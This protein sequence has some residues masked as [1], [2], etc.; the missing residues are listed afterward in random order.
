MQDY[1]DI[2]YEL[3]VSLFKSDRK[4]KE[5]IMSDSE[6]EVIKTL[7][8]EVTIYRGMSKDEYQSKKYRFSWTLDKS[9]AEMFVNR[10]NLLYK[11]E[12]VVCELIIPKDKIVAYFEERE[13]KEVI[14]LG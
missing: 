13:E 9:I 3:T 10:N 12:F 8:N 4:E 7:P 1:G 2:P 14:Y 11:K 5:F 6:R